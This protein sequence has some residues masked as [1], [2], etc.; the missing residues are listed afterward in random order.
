MM[1]NHH[2][3]DETVSRIVSALSQP[4]RIILFGS[5]A[6]GEATEDSDIDLLVVE[7]ELPDKAAE[8]LR[9]KQA[10][11]RIGVGVDLVL[12]SRPDFE[13]RRQVPGTLAYWASKEGKVLHESLA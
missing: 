13:R 10:V 5:Y 6:R 3:V 8:Y 9:L 4:A 1:L 2:Q 11:G 12:L 7:P